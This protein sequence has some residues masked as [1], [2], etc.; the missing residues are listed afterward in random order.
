MIFIFKYKVK[1]KTKRILQ[2]YKKREIVY[3]IYEDL[4]KNI[5]VIIIV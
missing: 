2:T 4:Y 5:N 3:K 1:K